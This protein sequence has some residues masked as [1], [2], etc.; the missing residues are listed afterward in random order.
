[1]NLQFETTQ[2]IT[3]DGKIYHLQRAI[4][5][6]EDNARFWS[7]W[8]NC[9]ESLRKH[10]QLRRETVSGKNVWVVYRMLPAQSPGTYAEFKAP[11]IVGN[12]SRLYPYQIKAVSR[13][14]YALQLHGAAA[15]G[16]DTGIGKTYHALAVCREMKLSPAVVCKVG[17]IAGWKRACE[18][19]A[20]TPIFIANW[21]MVKGAKFPFTRRAPDP[22]RGGYIYSWGLPKDTLLIFDEQHSANN[23]GSQ[24]YQLYIA[25]KGLA[26]L[27]LSATFADK[28]SRLKSLLYILG[29]STLEDFS[30]WLAARG[31]F[32][33]MHGSLESLSEYQDMIEVNRML[34]PRHGVRISYNDSDVK[35]FFPDCVIQTQL[36]ELSVSE[37]KK[38]NDLYLEML[39]KVKEYHDKGVGTAADPLVAELRY[40]QAAELFKAE[41]LADLA[42]EYL[43]EGKSVI[44]FVNYLDTLKYLAAK[45]KTRSVIYGEDSAQGIDREKTIEN[46]QNNSVRLIISMIDAGGQSIS[47]HDLIGKH[48]R[49][50]LI[51]PSYQS[52][53][54]KQVFGRTRRA[55]SKTIPIIKLVYA[56]NTIEEKV[57]ARVQEKIK[58]IDALMDGDIRDEL[59]REVHEGKTE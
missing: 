51:S 48:Q 13:L 38:Q 3:Q 9:K 15:D 24:N 16:S 18:Y 58:N 17:G 34:Y 55:G 19:M 41:A 56:A 21:E 11:Y 42:A 44:I 26:S 36:I 32:Q 39:R 22:F 6:P 30:A 33:N 31:H 47:L 20:I 54:I 7:T 27:S 59:A 2:N 12:T 4:L 43:Y 52:I 25:S 1:V 37:T 40:R 8:K 57:C 45:F 53:K 46:F 49:V 29:I 14:V 50:S 28:P 35:R 10:L 5:R 23:E